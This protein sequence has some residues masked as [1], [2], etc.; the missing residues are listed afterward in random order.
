MAYLSIKEYSIQLVQVENMSLKALPFRIIYL[1]ILIL[2]KPNHQH[3]YPPNLLWVGFLEDFGLK[4]KKIR[5]DNGSEGKNRTLIVMEKSML[6]EWKQSTYHGMQAI[7]LLSP[8]IWPRILQRYLMRD[9]NLDTPH[10]VKPIVYNKT[11]DIVEVVHD[12]ELDE[13]SGSKNEDENL[14]D[15]KWK[16]IKINLSTQDKVLQEIIHWKFLE[17]L[18]VV[19]ER[20]NMWTGYIVDRL[21]HTHIDHLLYKT[22]TIAYILMPHYMFLMILLQDE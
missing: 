22:F 17:I 20:E 16:M 4:I 12:V 21:A 15:S 6:S 14:D 3:I 2:E 7:G 9:F 5:S 18:G 11:R 19:Q 8:C 1:W 10:Q 13:T